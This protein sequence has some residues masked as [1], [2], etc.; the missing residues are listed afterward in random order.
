MMHAAFDLLRGRSC[1]CVRIRGLFF[2]PVGL[3][4]AHPEA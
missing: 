3:V 4:M 2:D 1:I